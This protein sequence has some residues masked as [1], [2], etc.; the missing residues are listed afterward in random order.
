[1]CT[2]HDKESILVDSP[3]SKE[4]TSF[5]EQSATAPFITPITTSAKKLENVQV[6]LD[7]V[8]AT[9]END[10]SVVTI[11]LKNASTKSINL[12]KRFSQNLFSCSLSSINSLE[13]VSHLRFCKTSTIMDD[14]DLVEI[15][16]NE[17]VEY[18]FDLDSIFDLKSPKF[19]NNVYTLRIRFTGILLQER[20]TVRSNFVEKQLILIHLDQS[21]MNNLE[22]YDKVTL[23]KEE[24]S[25]FRI[26]I[27]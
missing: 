4:Y 9:K 12:P 24:M 18:K 11:Q 1:M 13:E 8:D 21:E 15:E 5:H 17:I 3:L 26:K 25:C 6:D 20:K 23:T 19:V 10:K 16:P 27:V 7:I 2:P 14:F 22:V